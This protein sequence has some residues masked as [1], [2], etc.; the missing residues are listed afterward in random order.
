M[1]SVGS[2][3]VCRRSSAALSD[4]FLRD[5]ISSSCRRSAFRSANRRTLGSGEL[6]VIGGPPKSMG[7]GQGNRHQPVA[8]LDRKLE[9]GMN[10]PP[11]PA[12]PNSTPLEMRQLPPTVAIAVRRCAVGC[13]ANKKPWWFQGLYQLPEWRAGHTA[14]VPASATDMASSRSFIFR[15]PPTSLTRPRSSLKRLKPPITLTV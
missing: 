5:A 15:S 2:G 12:C 1:I 4:V 11:S 9:H 6:S 3:S 8:V 13:W 7:T 14:V 10:S